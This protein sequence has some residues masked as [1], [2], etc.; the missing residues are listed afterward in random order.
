VKFIVNMKKVI[1][2][3]VTSII[4]VMSMS[5]PSVFFRLTAMVT[6]PA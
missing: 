3:N 5:L 1:S 4:G 2:W 6:F